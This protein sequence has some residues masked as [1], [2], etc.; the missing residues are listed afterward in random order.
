MA[1]HIRENDD[2]EVFIK[3]ECFD[4]PDSKLQGR[5][6]LSRLLHHDRTQIDTKST[7]RLQ[8]G[9]EP[10]RFLRYYR[11]LWRELTRA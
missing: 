8:R 10:E 4:I 9:K 6:P 7:R 1:D 3:L 11:A 5:M 2:I